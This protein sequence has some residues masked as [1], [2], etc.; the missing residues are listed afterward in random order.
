M[1]KRNKVTMILMMFC[2]IAIGMIASSDTAYAKKITNYK[3]VKKLAL[4][5]V[6]GAKII[7]IDKSH[8]E[9]YDQIEHNFPALASGQ[10]ELLF[11]GLTHEEI[12]F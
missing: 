3:Q 5:E 2:F 6:K 12:S 1:K 8:D 4:K 7:E 11:W 10:V 9:G